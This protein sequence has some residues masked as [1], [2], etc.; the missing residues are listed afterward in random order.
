MAHRI[1]AV[2]HCAL[3]C[4]KVRV[5]KKLIFLWVAF[6]KDYIFRFIGVFGLTYIINKRRIKSITY[7]EQFIM[8]YGGLRG[9]VG[10]SLVT[11]LP[12]TNPMKDIFLTTTLVI[13]FFT[14]FIQGGTIKLLVSKLKI[15]KKAEEEKS[16]G[17]DVNLKMIDNVM[18]G[19]ESVMG[20]LSR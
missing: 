1:C 7:R 18:A 17:K 16:I 2:D 12:E 19:V 20:R 14:V 6:C 10:F 13:I 9:A 11:I 4:D 15:T 8:A 5:V 3:H